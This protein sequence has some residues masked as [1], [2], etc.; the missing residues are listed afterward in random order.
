M[1]QVTAVYVVFCF[2]FFGVGW[3]C[4]VCLHPEQLRANASFNRFCTV[5]GVGELE[6][7]NGLRNG[8]RFDGF[9][10]CVDAI[11]VAVPCAGIVCNRA[12]CVLIA[13]V[14]E[15][16]PDAIGG[17]ANFVWKQ[18]PVSAKPFHP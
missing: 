2:G 11:A 9:I 14:I 4:A 8:F 7:Q 6:R 1:V 16:Q 18:H 5:V 15:I 12:V 13:A 3:E 10:Q 17:N